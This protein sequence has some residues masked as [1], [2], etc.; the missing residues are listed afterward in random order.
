MMDKSNFSIF[1]VSS[2]PNFLKPFEESLKAD[3]PTYRLKD[4]DSFLIKENP[5][6]IKVAI[7]DGD[8][9]GQVTSAL[10][11]ENIFSQLGIIVCSN[12]DGFF[13]EEF[14]FHSGADF[15]LTQLNNYKS[16]N[17]RI[18]TIAKRNNGITASTTQTTSIAHGNTKESSISYKGLTI[19]PN[20]YLVKGS[21]DRV[22]KITPMQFKLL[23]NFF[24]HSG[25]LLSRDW[26]KTNI[27]EEQDISLRSIDAQVSKLKK[28]LPEVAEGIINIYGRGYI[29]N[30]DQEDSLA[31]AA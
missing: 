26:L 21:D 20:D 7:V 31:K 14:A 5:A 29:F 1:L 28:A 25:Q 24:S 16:L 3:F 11:E 17:L 8:L 12:L 4:T 22:I 10:R 13:K 18:K 30:M 2:N 15:F 9:C 19:F 23:I 6:A 27:W